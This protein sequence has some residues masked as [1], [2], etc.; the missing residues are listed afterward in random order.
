M[1][2]SLSFRDLKLIPELSKYNEI[3][4]LD[5]SMD[6]VVNSFLEQLG[7]DIEYPL[8]YLPS[9]HRDMSNKIAVG[10]RVV[11]EVSTNRNFINS[12]LCSVTE[13]LV[14]ASYQDVSLTKELANL[15]GN[16]LNYESVFGKD[17]EEDTEFPPELVEPDAAY[18][19][20]QIKTLERVRDEIRGPMFNSRGGLKTPKEYADYYKKIKANN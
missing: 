17:S 7:F 8:V 9:K 10:F 12:P 20:E 3:Q 18:V 14:A 1:S 2:R 6:T 15:M 11:G 19:A 13:R 5:L 4:L 16:N